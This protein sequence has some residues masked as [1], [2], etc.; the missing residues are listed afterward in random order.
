MPFQ[1]EIPATPRVISPSPTP[2]EL[3]ESK[4][5][6]RGPLTRSAS[7]RRQLSSPPPISE[8][9][10]GQENES[11]SDS[12]TNKRARTRS[13][14]PITK[15]PGKT[16][17]RL[18]GLASIDESPSKLKPL[19][20]GFLSPNG[21]LSPYSTAK[22]PFR[23]LSRSPSPLGLIPLHRHYRNFIHRHEIPRKLLHVSIGFITIDLYRRGVQ[24]LEITPWLLTALIPIAATDFLRHRFQTVNKLYIRCLGALM[25][26]TEVSGYNGVIWYLLGAFIVLRFFPKDVGVMGVLLLSWCDTAASTFGRLYGRYTPRIRRGKSLAGTLAACAV[27]IVTATAFWGYLVPTVSS[28]ANDP[29]NSFMFTGTLNLIPDY[30]KGALEWVGISRGITDKAVVSGPLALGVMSLWTGI[31]AAGSE[32]IDLFGWDDNLTIPVLSGVGMWGFLK[33]FGS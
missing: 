20:N 31:V 26:E 25:R 16:R 33:V 13:R 29:E 21:H 23:D 32:L 19:T 14:S 17:R 11:G 22:E 24:T 6:Y 15:S 28:F 1:N 3:S 30:V 18:S 10:R 7:A 27:G 5:G 8:E 9:D 12:S 2:S 4:D